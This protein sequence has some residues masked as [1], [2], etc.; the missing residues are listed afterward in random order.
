[1]TYRNPNTTL[2]N[3]NPFNA[4]ETEIGE[5]TLINVLPAAESDFEPQNWDTVLSD[6]PSKFRGTA[7]KGTGDTFRAASLDVPVTTS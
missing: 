7:V 6:S 2:S 1:M 3:V 4:N 5:I